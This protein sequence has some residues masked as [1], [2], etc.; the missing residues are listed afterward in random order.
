MFGG[1]TASHTAILAATDELPRSPEGQPDILH[2]AIALKAGM[3]MA[4]NDLMVF[5]SPYISM[6]IPDDIRGQ[7]EARE[8]AIAS[9]KSSLVE[10]MGS[11]MR[12]PEGSEAFLNVMS[13]DD[14][15]DFV[16]SIAMVDDTLDA[17]NPLVADLTRDYMNLPLDEQIEIGNAMFAATEALSADNGAMLNA[18]IISRIMSHQDGASHEMAG[19]DLTDDGNFTGPDAAA[20]G[21]VKLLGAAAGDGLMIRDSLVV[22]P[23][24]VHTTPPSTTPSVAPS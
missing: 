6:T 10:E 15:L 2:Y 17:N 9:M 16:R 18:Y 8:Q 24:I 20:A 7:I 13:V 19:V 21:D 3:E 14:R 12:S 5:Q 1:H 23:E 22:G 11:I 4:E